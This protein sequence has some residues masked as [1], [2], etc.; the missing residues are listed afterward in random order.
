[1]VFN[2]KSYLK[3]SKSPFYNEEL[4]PLFWEKE[5][6]GKELEWKLDPLVGKKLVDIA[7]DFI[8]ESSD[9]LKK[10]DVLDI[11][12]VGSLTGYNWNQY[13]PIKIPRQYLNESENK[14][15]KIQKQHLP[16]NVN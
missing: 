16:Y 13:S 9:V 3:E 14:K 10:K 6:E 2:F 4:C 11:Q 7:N 8:E 5:G 1:M 15:I 12:L